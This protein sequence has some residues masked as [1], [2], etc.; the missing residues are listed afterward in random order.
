[1]RFSN[2]LQYCTILANNQIATH[3]HRLRLNRRPHH[4]FIH[5]HKI[6]IYV[7]FYQPYA[8]QLLLC[9]RLC[10]CL[11]ST[12][13]VIMC[14]GCLAVNLLRQMQ[15]QQERNKKKSRNTQSKYEIDSPLKS[16]SMLLIRKC[17]C[18][19]GQPNGGEITLAH[20]GKFHL[21]HID[22]TFMRS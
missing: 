9:G 16:S 5:R 6:V 12:Q 17:P 18:I 13:R 11:W 7:N 2:G 22:C 10:V 20:K 1:M 4:Q 3:Y 14:L 19:R 8:A 15:C 21:I